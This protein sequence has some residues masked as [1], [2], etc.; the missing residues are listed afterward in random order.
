MRDVGR[1]VMMLMYAMERAITVEMET[2]PT[3][4]R[5]AMVLLK[6]TGAIMIA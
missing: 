5:V 4:E 3:Q 1:S 2:T 6:A